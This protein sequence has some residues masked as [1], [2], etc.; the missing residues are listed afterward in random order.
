MAMVSQFG[1]M[2]QIDISASVWVS[3]DKVWSFAS[4]SLLS[5]IEGVDLVYH[6][7][8]T[9]VE[10]PTHFNNIPEAQ[11]HNAKLSGALYKSVLNFEMTY[12]EPGSAEHDYTAVGDRPEAVI[13]A[14]SSKIFGFILESSFYKVAQII[15]GEGMTTSAYDTWVKYNKTGPEE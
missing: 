12:I 9:P 1:T 2:I 3:G 10:N 6:F 5:F 11:R 8:G 13:Y 4:R 14:R 7:E 15:N